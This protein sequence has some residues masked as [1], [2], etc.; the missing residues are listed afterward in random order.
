MILSHPERFFGALRSGLLG[1]SLSPEEVSGC[2]AIL[3]AC[4]GWQMSWTAYALG[5][6]FHE[7]AH[8][9]QPVREVGGE[10]YFHRM[11]DPNGLRPEIAKQL[12]NVHPGEGATY[13]GRGY[14]QLTGRG[15]Y[16]RA[17]EEL[18]ADGRLVRN[19]D[20]ALEPALAARIM[21][22]GMREGW[23]TG[24][25]L[26]QFLKLPKETRANFMAARRIINGQD[27]ADLIADY[28]IR[29]Q[30]ALMLGGWS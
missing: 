2:N 17:D 16:I 15:N 26:D 22:A 7:T 11:Y 13:C 18:K 20:A 21:E 1:P 6:A 25:R 5:T 23:F 19:P 9:M 3:D 10:A 27:R 28:A 14:V 8:S 29:F 12:G 24:R 4:K 30:D